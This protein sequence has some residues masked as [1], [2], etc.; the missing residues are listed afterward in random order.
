LSPYKRVL[1]DGLELR[2]LLSW[3]GMTRGEFA[4]FAGVRLKTLDS[5]T[6]RAGFA[7]DGRVATHAGTRDAIVAALGQIVTRRLARR[8]A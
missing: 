3:S 4:K 8:L 2:S 6:L 7:D 5:I 1:I